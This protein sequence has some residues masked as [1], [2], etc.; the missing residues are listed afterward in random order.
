MPLALMQRGVKLGPLK[1]CLGDGWP[2]L[3]T[4]HCVSL[5]FN[6]T[7]FRFGSQHN[8]LLHFY[9]LSQSL[10]AH[11]IIFKLLCWTIHFL[12]SK[13]KCLLQ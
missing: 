9:T 10:C 6:L 4:V 8:F 3:N 5:L 1:I 12:K 11:Y 13:V 7:P 2:S